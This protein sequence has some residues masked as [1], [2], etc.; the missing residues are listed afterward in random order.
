MKGQTR[1]QKRAGA[2]F[3]VWVTMTTILVAYQN[4]AETNF[5]T[6][7]KPNS[8]GGTITT[9]SQKME[10]KFVGPDVLKS[11]LVNIL[12][13]P[14][15]DVSV[16]NDQ[17]GDTAQQ[18]IQTNLA[19]LGKGSMAAGTFDSYSCGVVRFKAAMEVMVDACAVGMAKQS[20]RTKLFP[21]GTNDFDAV[22]RAFTGRLPTA[23]E[24][25]DLATL[26]RA[27]PVAKQEAG[28]CGAVASSLEAL[29]RI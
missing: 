1:A 18:R 5:N 17:G 2:K 23:G 22:Y 27:L 3:A 7:R 10:C 4:C 11:R 24:K 12:E 8:V 26:V 19:A 20:V 16:L 28:A 29:I 13:I 9:T 14:S 15:G 6:D 21:N 25:E